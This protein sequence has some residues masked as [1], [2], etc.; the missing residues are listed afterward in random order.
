MHP[1][2]KNMGLEG[3]KALIWHH[4]D[5]GMTRG[6]NA[7]FLE[8]YRQNRWPTASIIFCGEYAQDIAREV[9]QDPQ[10]DVGVHL[11]IAGDFVPLTSGPSLLSPD[12]RMW[13]SS[14]DAWSHLEVKEAEAEMRAQIE[15]ALELKV[16]LTHLDSHMGTVFRPDLLGVYLRLGLEYRVPVMLPRASNFPLPDALK[17]LLG[18]VMDTSPLPTLDRVLMGWEIAPEQKKSWYLEQ[19]R[20]LEPG[21][22]PFLHHAALETGENI[23]PGDVG[24]F[25]A[26]QDGEVLAALAEVQHLTYREIR[27]GMRAQ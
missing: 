4:D 14:E 2:F 20:N 19:L 12:G 8:L 18:Q 6:H 3:R 13:R 16:D 10:F 21:I 5:L 7:A 1:L 26:F 24:D 27:D 11:A 15:H 25:E 22:Y 9:G 23:W 17:T